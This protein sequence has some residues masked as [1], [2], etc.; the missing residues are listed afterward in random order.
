MKKKNHS[1]DIIKFD[2]Y[3]VLVSESGVADQ[4]ILFVLC[5]CVSLFFVFHFH[6]VVSVS[7]TLYSFVWH[8][9]SFRPDN[10]T[11]TI[12][13]QMLYLYGILF[14]LHK[15]TDPYTLELFGDGERERKREEGRKETAEPTNMER[16]MWA[17]AIIR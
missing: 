16:R 15:Q 8:L 12:H 13:W 2:I 6:F 1:I 9:F 11:V 5:E 14:D 17:I 3:I 4:F 7:F 10:S